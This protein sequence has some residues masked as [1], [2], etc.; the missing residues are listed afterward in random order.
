MVAT[1]GCGTIEFEGMTPLTFA[2]GESVVIPASVQS[3]MLRPQWELEFL[4]SSVPVETVAQ[5]D[6]VLI[7]DADTAPV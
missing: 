2:S 7:E 5:P 4:C 1:R 6:T 3:F